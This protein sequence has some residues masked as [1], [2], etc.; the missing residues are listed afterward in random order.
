M[1]MKPDIATKKDIE[2]IVRTFY[3]KVKTDETIGFF[4]SEI[5][6]IN[7]EAHIPKMC[8]FW[9]NVL[10]YTGEYEGNPLAAHRQIHQKYATKP[11]HFYRWIELFTAVVDSLHKGT[12][13]EKLKDH[14]KAIATVMM[15]K[16]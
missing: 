15:Q 11:E 14:A 12:N 1:S 10:F 13:A 7:W 3:E 8:S 9:E 16:I 4:F 5:V 2:I 6:P